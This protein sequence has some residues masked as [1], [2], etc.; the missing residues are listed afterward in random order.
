MSSKK[1]KHKTLLNLTFLGKIVTFVIR[2]LRKYRI[3]KL[4]HNVFVNYLN[5]IK[6]SKEKSVKIK[7][8]HKA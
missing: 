2:K 4:F 8:K 7:I 5:R 3:N 6:S 1:I